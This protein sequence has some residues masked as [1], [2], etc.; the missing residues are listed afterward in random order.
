[1]SE[2]QITSPSQIQLTNEG[3][4]QIEGLISKILDT[5]LFKW[6]I[7]LFAIVSSLFVATTFQ[8]IYDL[9]A[10]TSELVGIY[11]EKEGISSQTNNDIL[12]M[13][14]QNSILHSRID[15]LELVIMKLNNKKAR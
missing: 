10:K 6:S 15:S 5:R 4:A 11:K 8:R 1:M 12:K 2:T 13:A 9:N 7:A 3:Q 14:V